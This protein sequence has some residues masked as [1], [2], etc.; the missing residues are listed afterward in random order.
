M[1]SLNTEIVSPFAALSGCND[2]DPSFHVKN[3]SYLPHLKGHMLD[4]KDL[5]PT[6]LVDK[7][8][9]D[10]YGNQIKL[11]SYIIDFYNHGDF[12]AI[13]SENELSYDVAYTNIID[14]NILLRNLY[15]ICSRFYKSNDNNNRN[16]T[17]PDEFIS[18]IGEISDIFSEK[19]SN[20]KFDAFYCNVKQEIVSGSF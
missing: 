9:N 10:F 6:M 17:H 13:L 7:D 3:M 4:F 1:N 8:L 18:A 20:I 15:H 12:L 5:Y 11:N 2:L 19:V 14:F 16:K